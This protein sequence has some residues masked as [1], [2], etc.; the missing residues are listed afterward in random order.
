MKPGDI[1]KVGGVDYWG[2]PCPEKVAAFIQLPEPL[3]TQ[4]RGPASKGDIITVI[5]DRMAFRDIESVEVLHPV[6]G[7]CHI[8]R[9]Y[10]TAA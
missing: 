6:L 7:V 8:S 2:D 5:N 4:T 1:Y 3:L 10:L 9:R